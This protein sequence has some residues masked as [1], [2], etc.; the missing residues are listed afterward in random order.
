M[1]VIGERKDSTSSASLSEGSFEGI[2]YD[3]FVVDASYCAP[4]YVGKDML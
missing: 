4:R 3:R 1:G 2:E